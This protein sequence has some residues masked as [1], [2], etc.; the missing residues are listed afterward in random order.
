MSGVP[1]LPRA[2]AP[3]RAAPAAPRLDSQDRAPTGLRGRALPPQQLL[4]L[5]CQHD[6]PQLL[7]Q[8]GHLRVPRL[9]GPLVH[10]LLLPQALPV[11]PLVGQEGLVELLEEVGLLP[12]LRELGLCAGELARCPAGG[13]AL[14]CLFGEAPF[15]VLPLA[16]QLGGQQ[17][18]VLG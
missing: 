12:E 4:G 6:V 14:G 13:L 3:P 5:Q 2:P 17:V 10:G 1:P 9:Q 16:V 18:A 7:P 11:I 8:V 15:E